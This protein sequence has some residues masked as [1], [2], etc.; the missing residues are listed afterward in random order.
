MFVETLS[1]KSIL[2][3]VSN[4]AFVAS[5]SYQHAMIMYKSCHC[6]NKIDVHQ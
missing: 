6:L 4:L 3:V 5:E 1:L 2:F